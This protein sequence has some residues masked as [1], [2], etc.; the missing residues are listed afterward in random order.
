MFVLSVDYVNAQEIV[1]FRV[2]LV[3]IAVNKVVVYQAVLILFAAMPVHKHLVKYGVNPVVAIVVTQ[4]QIV[5]N[6]LTNRIKL[7]KYNYSKPLRSKKEKKKL[8]ET[9]SGR[10]L[11]N[12]YT[13]HSAESRR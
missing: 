4:I 8:I 13:G 9:F 10:Q 2:L 6:H 3:N 5:G 1:I 12:S 11:F 7:G